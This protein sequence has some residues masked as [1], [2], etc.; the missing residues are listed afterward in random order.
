MSQSNQKYKRIGHGWVRTLTPAY[1]QG[2]EL[3]LFQLAAVLWLWGRW[4]GK[5]SQHEEDDEGKESEFEQEKTWYPT[6]WVFLIPGPFATQDELFP[7]SLIQCE[8]D[9]I[10]CS[11]FFTFSKCKFCKFCKCKFINFDPLYLDQEGIKSLKSKDS[12]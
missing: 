1:E 7:C 8:S 5:K 10:I 3:S 6:L 9:Q 4:L 2:N 12:L 11:I